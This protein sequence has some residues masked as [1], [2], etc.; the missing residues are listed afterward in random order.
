MFWIAVGGWSVAVVAI[1]ALIYVVLTMC[2]P[3]ALAWTFGS[4]PRSTDVYRRWHI[5]YDRWWPMSGAHFVPRFLGDSPEARTLSEQP[6]P[7]TVGAAA[8]ACRRLRL[9]CQLLDLSGRVVATIDPQGVVR[10]PEEIP[11]RK[12]A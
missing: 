3:T 7:I 1:G 10:V 4:G 5:G 11:K 9:E 12:G 2:P 8:T 6:E